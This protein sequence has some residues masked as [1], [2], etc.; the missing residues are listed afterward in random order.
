[1]TAQLLPNDDSMLDV[2]ADIDG[3]GEPSP[4]W[5]NPSQP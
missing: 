4:F 2:L 1:V 3:P 5:A